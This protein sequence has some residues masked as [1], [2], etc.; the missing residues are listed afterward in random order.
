VAA[1]RATAAAS[2]SSAIPKA[3]RKRGQERHGL[4]ASL[5]AGLLCE[6]LRAFARS[7]AAGDAGAGELAEGLRSDADVAGP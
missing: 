5:H 3:E 4:L 7:E 6:V 2:S 1:T